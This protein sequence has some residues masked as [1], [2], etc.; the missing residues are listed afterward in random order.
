LRFQLIQRTT[1]L[2]TRSCEL[3]LGIGSRGWRVVPIW[4]YD[5]HGFTTYELLVPGLIVGLFL[6]GNL[7]LALFWGFLIMVLAK[8]VYRDKPK[9]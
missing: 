6:L 7:L 3:W 1:G 9:F 5:C 8:E 2:Q 4:G